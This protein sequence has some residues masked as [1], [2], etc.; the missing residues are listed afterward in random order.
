MI[1]VLLGT[2]SLIAI[3]LHLLS[4]Q[5][6]WEH[7]CNYAPTDQTYNIIRLANDN[8]AHKGLQQAGSQADQ[9][10]L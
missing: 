4:D 1:K 2:L 9:E 7:D 8:N 3:A 10:A 6:T 5:Q